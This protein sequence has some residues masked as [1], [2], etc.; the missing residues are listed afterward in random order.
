MCLLN[1]KVMTKKEQ[2]KIQNTTQHLYVSMVVRC[3]VTMIYN[4]VPI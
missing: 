4:C 2:S 3:C 1:L